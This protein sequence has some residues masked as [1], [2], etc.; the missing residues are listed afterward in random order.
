LRQAMALGLYWFI[1][2]EVL[3]VMFAAGAVKAWSRL[4]PRE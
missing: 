4:F 3:K 2:A 1:F